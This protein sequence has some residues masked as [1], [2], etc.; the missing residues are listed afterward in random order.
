MSRSADGGAVNALSFDVEDWYHGL[1]A[2]PD[3]W[4]GHVDRLGVGLDTLLALLDQ[5][6]VKATFFVLAPLAKSHPDSIRRI[7]RLGHEISSHGCSHLPIYRQTPDQFRQDITDSKHILEDAIEQPIFGYRAPFF[8]VTP[9]TPW[10][11]EMIAS[12]GFV[13]DSSIFPVYNPRYGLP[14]AE[15]FP[16]CL[17][18][19]L[20]EFPIS[21]LQMGGLNLPF[22]GGIYARFFGA[23]PV[24]WGIRHLNRK[25]RPALVYFH[26][27]EFDPAHPHLRFR[28]LSSL[29]H[30]THYHNLK[31]TGGILIQLL[32]EFRFAP[33]RDVLAQTGLRYSQNTIEDTYGEILQSP[34]ISVLDV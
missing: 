30:F 4:R 10:A 2:S 15:R 14:A 17:P 9:G 1:C 22:S 3:D 20:I 27:W 7:A 16:H 24:R 28:S 32:R 29:Y 11:L 23:R 26:P 31:G 25:D 19:G 13:Y 12:V 33:I 5:A 6:G 18:G 21:T 8:S 34:T